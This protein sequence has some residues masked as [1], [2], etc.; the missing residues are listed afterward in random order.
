MENSGVAPS[1]D[2]FLLQPGAVIR[3]ENNIAEGQSGIE[4]AGEP[5]GEHQSGRHRKPVAFCKLCD[6]FFCPMPVINTRQLAA[7]KNFVSSFTAKQTNV[8][9]ESMRVRGYLMPESRSF[10]I[11]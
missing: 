1:V 7:L 10:Q 6:A 11:W 4:P 9:I 2:Q 5:A 3:V 8:G